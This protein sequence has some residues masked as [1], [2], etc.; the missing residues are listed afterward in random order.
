L[1]LFIIVIIQSAE[2]V[3]LLEPITQSGLGW[4]R[5][6]PRGLRRLVAVL[7]HLAREAHHN[8]LLGFGLEGVQLLALQERAIAS[9]MSLLTALVARP[10]ARCHETLGALVPDVS[11]T[12]THGAFER[13]LIGAAGASIA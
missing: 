9:L 3:A 8:I 11:R 13:R 5:L 10:I 12:A 4:H 7:L 1:I 2:S 6:R